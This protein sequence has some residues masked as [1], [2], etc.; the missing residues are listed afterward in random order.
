MQMKTVRRRSPKRSS[1]E[2]CY[3]GICPRPIDPAHHF[4]ID[5]RDGKP[6]IRI[7]ACSKP[8]LDSLRVGYRR[9]EVRGGG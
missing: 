2:T 8:H 1:H 4:D 6:H 3:T 7:Y 5:L 9:F